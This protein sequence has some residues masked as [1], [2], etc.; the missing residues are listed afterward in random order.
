LTA[1]W[2][3][4]DDVEQEFLACG[5]KEFLVLE[6]HPEFKGQW[7]VQCVDDGFHYDFR[8]T[9]GA[10]RAVAP[11]HL[12]DFLDLSAALGYKVTFADDPTGILDA[13]AHLH[14]APEVALNSDL[15]GTVNGMLP[16][17]V[18]GFNF[19]KDL[20]AGVVMWSTGTGKTVV[21]SALLKYHLDV[22]ACDVAFF[23]VKAHNKVNTQRT[24][25]GLTG[26]D[27]VVLDGPKKRRNDILRAAVEAP[28]APVVITNY[29][30][31][32]VDHDALIPLVEGK[33]VLFIWDE[34]PTKLKNR[35]T[36]L[37]HSVRKVLYRG[38]HPRWDMRRAEAMT[39]YMLSATPIE[40]NPEDFFN[41]VRMLDPRIFGKVEDFHNHFV[42]SFDYFDPNKPAVFHNLEKMGLVASHIVH[43]VD[44]EDPDIAEQFPDVIEEVVYVDWDDK[45]REIYDRLAK[46]AKLKFAER[47]EFEQ[48]SILA[49]IGVMQMMCDMPS[50]VNDSAA[51]RELYEA[52]LSDLVVEEGVEDPDLLPSGSR[53][54]L[55]L[56]TVLGGDKL[57]D[58]R[59]TKLDTL[60]QLLTD[61]H[62]DEKVVVFTTF[63]DALIPKLAT[64]LDEWGVTYVTY[65]GTQAEK[66]AAQDAF[67]NDPSIQVFLSSDAGSDSINLECAS[68]VI[69]YDLPWKYATLVQRHNRVHRVTS[70]FGKVR[71]YMLLMANSVEER[72]LKIIRKKHQYHQAVFKGA[73]ADQATSARMTLD[74][75]LFVLS[76]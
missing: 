48:T 1:K 19:L 44:K 66:Q 34:M 37:Y 7:I 75:L 43:Q 13:Y 29:E 18:Q 69:D 74:E 57:T 68:V 12:D 56:L 50:M 2:T 38:T 45:D 64:Y 58:D 76:G 28:T 20:H 46:A 42:R 53:A 15:P 10:Y 51:M 47:D 55:E 71:Y 63:N 5:G 70:Q 62:R 6:E 41:C 65:R 22:L 4:L 14:D 25:L 27:S 33:R 36:K 67:V 23:V 3:L 32:R 16:Y 26:I 40:N 52:A 73:V 9:L 60:A 35:T 54:A 31:F 8:D 61:D 21:A 49:L 24:L 11:A 72:K 39:Q 59:H 17:Q 30:K